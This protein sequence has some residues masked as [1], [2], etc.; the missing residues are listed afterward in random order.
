MEDLKEDGLL[1][2]LLFANCVAPHLFFRLTWLSNDVRLILSN[3]IR[4][5]SSDAAD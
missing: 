1:E 4:R 2:M 5:Y 3:I